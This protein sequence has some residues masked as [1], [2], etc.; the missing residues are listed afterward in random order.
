M[1]WWTL[2]LKLFQGLRSKASQSPLK[3]LLIAGAALLTFAVIAALLETCQQVRQAQNSIDKSFK[4]AAQSV[5]QPKAQ[6]ESTLKRTKDS[7]NVDQQNAVR[8]VDA[9]PVQ[10][11]QRTI[12]SLYPPR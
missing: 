6:R 10:Q 11:L 8:R 5:A 3:T 7:I 4:R 2:I 1:K 9:M 12:D